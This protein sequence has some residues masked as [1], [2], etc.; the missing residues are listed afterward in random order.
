MNLSNDSQIFRNSISFP[1]N[2]LLSEK[3]YATLFST[4]LF[5]ARR[6]S[7]TVRT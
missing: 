5:S 1:S 2:I 3:V 6:S 7:D 4:K